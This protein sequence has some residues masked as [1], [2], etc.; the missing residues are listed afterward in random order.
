MKTLT[1]I[2]FLFAFLIQSVVAAPRF[3]TVSDIH[4]GSKNNS[5]EGQDTGPDFLANTFAKLMHLTKKVDFILVLGDLPT[6]LFGHSREKVAYEKAVFHGLYTSDSNSLPM[7]YI[8]G[9]NDPIQGNYQPFLFQGKSPIDYAEDWQGACVFCK[10][11]LIDDTHMSSGG[12]YSSYVMP[13][14]KDIILLV[15]NTTQWAKPPFF[16]LKYSNQEKDAQAQLFWL[17]E[18]LRTHSAKQLLIAMHIPPGVSYKGKP[19]WQPDYLKQ[20]V[21]ILDQYHHL[22]GEM[23]LLTSHTHMEEFR[24]IHLSDGSA[25]YAYST[26]SISRIHYNNPAIKIFEMDSGMRIKNFI[27]YYTSTTPRWTEQYYQAIHS[28]PDSI[29]PNCQNK[30]LADCLNGLSDEEVCHHLEKGLFYGVK[31]KKVDN[32]SC[33]ITYRVTEQ[34]KNK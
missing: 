27:T 33:R 16:L 2:F 13:G 3:L 19:L 15:L 7:F 28:S 11:L 9:N 21:S 14:N 24:K 34:G 25:V 23:S 10:G 26:P 6:H 17:S 30:L 4:Y 8:S 32:K 1:P 31:N 5:E 12:Y 18:Q 22:Y 29:F 20:F